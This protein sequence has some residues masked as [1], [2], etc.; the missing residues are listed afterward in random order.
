MQDIRLVMD[1]FRTADVTNKS[2]AR[3]IMIIGFVTMTYR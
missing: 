1:L 2:S 3:K